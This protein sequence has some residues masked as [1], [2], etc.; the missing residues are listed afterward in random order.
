VTDTLT[1]AEFRRRRGPG[2][3]H[4]R[5]LLPAPIVAQPGE[6][7]SAVGLD[8]SL[9]RPAACRFDESGALETAAWT[10][11]P[12]ERRRAPRTAEERGQRLRY[13]AECI[14]TFCAAAPPTAIVVEDFAWAKRG[15]HANLGRL[16]GAVELELGRRGNL[17]AFIEVH[18]N[19]ARKVVLGK[20]PRREPNEPQ[21]VI[22]ERVAKL[23]RL[24]G[25]EFND[26]DVA[27]AFVLAA[28]WLEEQR[29]ARR[30]Q[31]AP[32]AD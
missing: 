24:Q 1:A 27:D 14:A 26:A 20:A 23:L 32:G 2:R 3:G 13:L 28:W 7:L 21:R 29:V 18:A 11:P 30:L 16:R 4:R 12:G 17:P 8:L 22:K 5:R 19:T 15:D 9:S 10:W 25:R 6:L 31:P